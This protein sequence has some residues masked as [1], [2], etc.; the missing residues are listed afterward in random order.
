MPN[1][2]YFV[3]S[4]LRVF[5][6]YAYL[7]A[8]LVLAVILTRVILENRDLAKQSHRALCAQKEQDVRS[9]H[10]TL[11][12]LKEHPDGGPFGRPLL[13]RSLSATEKRLKANE[14]VSC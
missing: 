10:E 4:R 12:Y 14:D 5:L 11:R 3:T 9:K 2:A 7:I 1:S 8:I 6:F 13:L